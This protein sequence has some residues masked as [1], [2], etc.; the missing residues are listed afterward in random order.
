MSSH[1]DYLFSYANKTIVITGGAGV[2]AGHI[3]DSFL[4]AG[5]RLSLWGRSMDGLDAAV[6]KL[7]E[8]CQIEEGQLHCLEVDCRNQSELQ[9]AYQ[10]VCSDY[11]TPQIMVNAVGGN[12][13]KCNF[14]DQDPT[15]FMETIELNLLAGMLLPIQ[16][17]TGDWIKKRIAGSVLCIAS[18]ASYKGLSGVWGYNAAKAAVMNLTAGAAREFAQ[19]NIRINSISPGFFVGKQ[20]HDLLIQQDEPLILTERGK[21]ILERTAMGR[22]G[23]SEDLAGVVLFLCSNQA[24]G[25]ITGI[26]IPVDGGFLTDTI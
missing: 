9:E 15:R 21:D 26:D 20:N 3:A 22:F 24:A 23:E 8:R 10:L 25:F 12:S 1:L 13:D 11:D 18:M 2:I 5:A 14:N 19:Y 6:R 4:K 17:C 7:H 16:V